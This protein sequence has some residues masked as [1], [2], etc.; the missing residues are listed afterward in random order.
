MKEHTM[1][2]VQQACAEL[3]VERLRFVFTPR[4]RYVT[5]P[6]PACWSAILTEARGRVTAG[7]GESMDEAF[8]RATEILRMRRAG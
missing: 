7:Q 6:E 8:D 2:E 4:A 3:D 5:G 1:K